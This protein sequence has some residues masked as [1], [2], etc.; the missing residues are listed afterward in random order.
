MGPPLIP[1]CQSADGRSD[2]T[3]VGTALGG[4]LGASDGLSELNADAAV[5]EIVGTADGAALGTALCAALGTA[6]G[7]VL[8]T[9]LDAVPLSLVFVAF[10]AVFE[11]SHQP[12]P[13]SHLDRDGL[14]MPPAFVHRP[15]YKWTRFVRFQ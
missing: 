10:D 13:H 3:S 5:G 11:Q 12:P 7:T 8:G 9:L 14:T 2:G 15:H 6:L 1:P 4:A